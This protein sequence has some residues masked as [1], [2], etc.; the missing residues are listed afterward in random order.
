MSRCLRFL[1]ATWLPCGFCVCHYGS[2]ATNQTPKRT[3]KNGDEFAQLLEAHHDLLE[4]LPASVSRADPSKHCWTNA[5]V[6]KL[7]RL[8]SSP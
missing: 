2:M 8:H 6:P 7:P 3:R 1:V 4:G 5:S